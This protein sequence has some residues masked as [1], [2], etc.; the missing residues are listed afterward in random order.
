MIAN[1]LDQIQGEARTSSTAKPHVDL[2]VESH[3]FVKN[4]AEFL[5][6]PILDEGLFYY[7]CR[8]GF[9][10]EEHIK[11]LEL[12]IQINDEAYNGKLERLLR[13]VEALLYKNS[14]AVT[15]E[16]VADHYDVPEEMQSLSVL[17]KKLK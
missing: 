8:E 11:L 4:E 2:F 10:P 12:G 17:R 1:L 9:R 7:S 3:Q 5:V 6:R 15:H 16:E 14:V 13:R